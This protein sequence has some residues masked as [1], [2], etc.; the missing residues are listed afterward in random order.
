[1]NGTQ[2]LPIIHPEL[3]SA[4]STGSGEV[5]ADY[6]HRTLVYRLARFVPHIWNERNTSVELKKHICGTK[7]THRWNEL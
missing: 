2:L 1:M 6:Q 7:G 3:D 5:P 4:G